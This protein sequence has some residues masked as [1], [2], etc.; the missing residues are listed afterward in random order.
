[1]KLKILI[2][3]L[4]VSSFAMS[5]TLEETLQQLLADNAKGYMN[6]VAT[7]FGSGMN[8]GTFHTAKPHKM[9]GFDV[10]INAAFVTPS[11]SQLEYDFVLPTSI[12]VPMDV[13]GTIYNVTLDGA[14][15]FPGEHKSSTFFGE[16]QANPISPDATYAETAIKDQLVNTYGVPQ[17]IADAIPT[18]ELTSAINELT[19]YTPIGSGLTFF[20]AVVPQVSIG[21]PMSIELMLRGM[22]EIDLPN[23]LGKFSFI[24][25]GAKI[26]L[27]QFIPIPNIALP[28][29]SVGYYMTN[30]SIGD[31]ISSKNSIATLQVS[32]SIP[33]ITVYGGFGLESSSLD[34][35]YTPDASTGLTKDIEFNLEGENSFRT[36]VGARLKLFLLTINAD[37]NVG[38]FNT[39]NFGFGLTL[40]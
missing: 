7:A 8:S 19:L 38:E 13:Q 21:L 17:L 18:S 39:L 16:D 28:R 11:D 14:L 29:V 15:L 10:K 24:G 23:D 2:I 33:F 31:L 27:N 37:Y 5:Q 9:L 32:K 20:G 12:T 30:M 35:V 1:M 40:R 22:P 4:L 36:T 6:P 25:Y 26:E 34:V 3:G